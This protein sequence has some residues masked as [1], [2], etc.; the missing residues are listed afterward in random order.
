MHNTLVLVFRLCIQHGVSHHGPGSIG[1]LFNH[2]HQH[3]HTLFAHRVV[4]S[5]CSALC[6][7]GFIIEVVENNPQLLQKQRALRPPPLSL[8]PPV[9]VNRTMNA[10]ILARLSHASY[11]QNPKIFLKNSVK[12][13]HLLLLVI[14]SHVRAQVCSE[15]MYLSIYI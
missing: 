10:H 11:H 9:A 6:A 14:A 8:P 15:N 3:K 1:L 7:V 4:V 2:C 12:W 13:S 5:L